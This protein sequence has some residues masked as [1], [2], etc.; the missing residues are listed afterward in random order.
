MIRNGLLTGVALTT[1][2]FGGF[3]FLKSLSLDTP[4]STL[5][6]L[7]GVLGLVILFIGI[8]YGVKKSRDNSSHKFTYLQAVKSGVIISII[9]AIMV[10][11]F[12]FLYVTTINP[13]FANDMV[14]EA[15]Q[16]LKQSGAAPEEIS[17]RLV[18]IRE[19]FSV[20]SQIIIPLIAQSTMGTVFSFVLAIFLR[21][22]KIN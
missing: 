5:R 2:L 17:R 8:F 4:L 11:T 20:S 9:V 10:S 7:T 16:S 14:K 18:S 13:D 19:E 15:E 1:W 21:S 6:T 22:K 12:S 3:S